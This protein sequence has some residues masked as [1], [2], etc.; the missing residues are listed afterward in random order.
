MNSYNFDDFGNPI[1]TTGKLPATVLYSDGVYD[2]ALAACYAPI[3]APVRCQACSP[4]RTST[5]AKRHRRPAS[6]GA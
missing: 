6:G 3:A 1:R 2:P 5:P 4:A